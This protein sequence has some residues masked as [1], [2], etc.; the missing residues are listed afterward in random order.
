[1]I[2]DTSTKHYVAAQKAKHL[3]F[4]QVM[5]EPPKKEELQ[6]NREC[7]KWRSVETIPRRRLTEQEINMMKQTAHRMRQYYDTAKQDI[8]AV[9]PSRE[10]SFAIIEDIDLKSQTMPKLLTLEEIVDTIVCIPI[11]RRNVI[12][13]VLDS[14]VSVKFPEMA[15]VIRALAARA[16]GRELGIADLDI[17]GLTSMLWELLKRLGEESQMLLILERTETDPSLLCDYYITFYNK[18]LKVRSKK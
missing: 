6:A 8:M 13:N 15:P 9:L 18:W 16:A 4:V 1:M 12:F 11:P 14:V 7:Y 17:K 2:V 3:N 5:T 10:A